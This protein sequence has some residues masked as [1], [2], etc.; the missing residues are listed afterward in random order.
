MAK[1]PKQKNKSKFKRAWLLGLIVLL[2][3]SVPISL[4]LADRYTFLSGGIPFLFPSLLIGLPLGILCTVG[5]I[6]IGGTKKNFWSTVVPF[7]LLSLTLCGIIL[8]FALNLNCLFDTSEPQKLTVVIEDKEFDS[9]YRSADRKFIF[10][11]EGKEYSIE[12]PWSVYNR[13]EEGD[14]FEIELRQ[15]AFHRP[16]FIADLD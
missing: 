8:S 7:A 15:G 6:R 5:V 11:Y 4:S 2:C 12:V 1:S 9:S 10:T 13:Y 3:V 16:F 14:L